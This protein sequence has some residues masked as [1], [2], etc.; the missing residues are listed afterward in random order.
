MDVLPD[1]MFLLG[2]QG[3]IFEILTGVDF[4][5][6]IGTAHPSAMSITDAFPYASSKQFEKI[7]H[8][9]VALGRPQLIEYKDYKYGK[10]RWFEGRTAL[11]GMTVKD[12][13]AVVFIA[14]DITEKKSVQEQLQRL[15]RE[16]EHQARSDPLTGT[17][18]R[19]H[20]MEQGKRLASV[21]KRNGGAVSI[22]IFDV[23]W[24]K[25]VNDRHGHDTG[26]LVLKAVANKVGQGIRD[27]DMLGRWG[28]EEFI[29]LCQQTN[30]DEAMYLAER[31]R[32]ILDES[33]IDPVGRMTASFGVASNTGNESLEKTIHRA[34][35]ALYAAKHAGRNRVFANR[36]DQSEIL[37]AYSA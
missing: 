20:I 24:F 13:K 28:G 11:T 2:E 17:A 29:I 10:E 8:E 3:E 21:V 26:D 1:L 36:Y 19:R 33:P 37:S 22:I 34:D 30:L 12:T 32:N 9:T 6:E 5:M 4:I 31:L 23:D 35:K 15:N 14:R 7:I 25:S 18:N 16:L 27:I